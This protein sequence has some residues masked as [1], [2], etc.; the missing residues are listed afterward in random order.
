[1]LTI[2][3]ILSACNRA[4]QARLSSES[5]QILSEEEA[6]EFNAIAARI[7]P[8]DETPGAIE[9]GVIYFIDNVMNDGMAGRDEELLDLRDGLRELQT[10][11]ALSYG[12]AYFFQLETSQQDQLLTDI[13]NSTFFGSMRFLALA[14]MFS[15]P[16]YGGNRDNI[17]YQL[18]GY[19]PRVPGQRPTVFT[20]PISWKRGNRDGALPLQAAMKWISS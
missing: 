16:E 19:Q 11:I 1:M 8:S 14:G 18:I 5:F 4:E 10:A 3:M 2:P 12:G 17:G 6:N 9:A 15:L 13:E 7:I 20:T